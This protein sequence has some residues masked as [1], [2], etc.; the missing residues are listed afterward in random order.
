M[1]GDRDVIHAL[2]EVLAAELVAINQ[3]FM[4]AKMC[5]NWGYLALAEHSR[6]ESIDEMRHAEA[7]MKR[8]LFLEGLPNL[9]RLDKLNVGQNV[10]E[11]FKSD[12]E[13]E[14]AAVARLNSSIALCREKG[15][16]QSE[17]LLREILDGEE[18]HIDWLETQLD[19]LQKLGEPL[20]LSQKLSHH[21]S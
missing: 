1:K 2:N 4:H 13:L 18:E 6:D 7:I 12:L 5:E 17:H 11:Q 21:K 9:Q 8:I 14:Y 3:Y 19:L 15:D 20:Y 16:H 10:P